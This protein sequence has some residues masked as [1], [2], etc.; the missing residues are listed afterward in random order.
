M[1]KSVVLLMVTI[2]ISF[3]LFF[4]AWIAYSFRTGV[5]TGC[6]IF[7]A[8][9]IAS[10]LMIFFTKRFS[11][12][13]VFLPLLFSV[14]WSILLIPFDIP[15]LFSAPAAIGSGFILTMCLW[16]VH[17][18][19]GVGE[20]WLILPVVVFLYEMLPVNI[21]G[22]FD[23]YFA[24]GGDVVYGILLYSKTIYMNRELP[25]AE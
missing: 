6:C 4:G 23:D 25:G 19:H 3:V 5:I 20:E 7:A 17:H 15:S 10:T 16:R 9:M 8:G 22:P 24:F 1:W 14:I 12:V 2:P 13:D 18:N 21:P 11:L